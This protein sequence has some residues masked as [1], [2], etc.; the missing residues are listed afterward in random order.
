MPDSLP[1]DL[2]DRSRLPLGRDE[3]HL[4]VSEGF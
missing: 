1:R 4:V 3:R 2:L